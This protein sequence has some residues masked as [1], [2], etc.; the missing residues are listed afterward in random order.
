MDSWLSVGGEFFIR[1]FEL[2]L[3]LHVLSRFDLVM[4]Y[5]KQ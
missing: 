5:A 3:W 4:V 1:S 2:A